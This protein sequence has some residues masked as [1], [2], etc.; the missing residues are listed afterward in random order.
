M[1]DLAVSD[2][3]TCS[4][5]SVP[6]MHPQFHLDK[7]LDVSSLGE[8]WFNSLVIENRLGHTGTWECPHEGPLLELVPAGFD[9]VATHASRESVSVVVA[10]GPE[11]QVLLN[12][13]NKT[14]VQV[15]VAAPTG[16]DVGRWRS[17]FD[18]RGRIEAVPDTVAGNFWASGRHGPSS[19]RRMVAA[20]RYCD[21]KGNY[22]AAASAHLK[23]LSQFGRQRNRGGLIMWFGPAGTGKT[24]AVRAMASEWSG[25]RELNVITDIEKLLADADYLADVTRPSSSPDDG[26][27]RAKLIVAEDVDPSLLAEQQAGG[28]G[29]LA[30]LLGLTD[31]LMAS[32]TDAIVLLTTNARRQQIAPSLQRPGRCL[33]LVEFG[34]L[35]IAEANRWLPPGV[36]RVSEATTLAELYHRAGRVDQIGSSER[37]APPVGTYL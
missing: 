18:D 7:Y 29:G 14:A 22:A 8:V 23:G 3:S 30:R 35:S 20:A 17:A 24:T 31:G 5:L 28:T 27:G 2:R 4:N 34:A 37:V 36:E 32:A 19:T 26:D 1:T 16:S 11:V 13:Q 9:V 6:V 10:S 25:D 15:Q 12:R 21:V 33:A